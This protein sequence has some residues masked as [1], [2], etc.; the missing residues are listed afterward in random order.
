[1]KIWLLLS[2]E[3]R[4]SAPVSLSL[5]H[6]SSFLAPYFTWMCGGVSAPHG[7]SLAASS[8]FPIAFAPYFT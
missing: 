6:D 1:M 3:N 7:K 5:P 2:I 4:S 8:L